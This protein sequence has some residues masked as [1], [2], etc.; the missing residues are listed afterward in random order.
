MASQAAETMESSLHTQPYVPTPSSSS[1][2]TSSTPVD[3]TQTLFVLLISLSDEMLV[4][5]V[6]RS[7]HLLSTLV[8]F[9]VKC[10]ETR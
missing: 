4:R 8:H 7:P 3:F 5:T 10:L 1:S 2:L 9:T 6:A